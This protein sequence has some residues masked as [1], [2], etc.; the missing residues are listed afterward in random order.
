M[1]ALNSVIDYYKDIIRY[2]SNNLLCRLLSS[3]LQ[4][5]QEF[6]FNLIAERSSEVR[7]QR[8]QKQF[9]TFILRIYRMPGNIRREMVNVK[10]KP[11][12]SAQLDQIWEHS[13]RGLP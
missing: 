1:G 9:L 6:A 12:I 3:R 7:Y 4:S 13:I 11:E 2:T 8:A 10:I 5:R